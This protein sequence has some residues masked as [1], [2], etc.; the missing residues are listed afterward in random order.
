MKIYVETYGCTANKSDE[1]LLIGL[2]QQNGHQIVDHL[3]DAKV[4]VL[5]TCTVIGTTEQRMLSRLRVFYKTKKPIIV[6]GCMPTVQA[7]LITSVA[8]NAILLPSQHIQYINDVIE[9]R[10]PV[11]VETIK[12]SFPK[13]YH[14][15]IAPVLIAEGCRF[16]CSYCITHIARGALRSFPLDG[17]VTDVCSAIRQGCKEI[18]L[19]AQDTASYGLDIGTNLGVLLGRITGLDGLFRVRVGMMNPVTARRNLPSLITAYQHPHIYK[20]LHVPVQSGN[21]EILKKMNRGYTVQDFT[22]LVQQF[23]TAVPALTLST[24]VILGFPSETEEQFTH[25]IHLL[26]EIQPDIINITRFSARP[27]TAAKT[28]NGRIPTH[29]AKE[30]SRQ[31]T[32]ICMEL[33]LRKNKHHVGKIYSVLVT[34]KGKHKTVTGRT[35]SYKQVVLTEPVPLGSVVEA[36]MIDATPSYLVGKLI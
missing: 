30:R 17:V 4:L 25:T 26:K 35:D 22:Q 8:P 10:T 14:G 31:T 5:L 15:V 16:S 12:T 2:L 32:E 3:T 21:D 9:G 24:D 1:H 23:Q 13:R 7:D 18:Q 29:I 28:M 6:S 36:T 33:T 27:F 11:F 20:F 34:E 19:T